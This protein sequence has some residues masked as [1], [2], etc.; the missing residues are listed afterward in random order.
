MSDYLRNVYVLL[1]SWVIFAFTYSIVYPYIELYFTELGGSLSLVGIVFS[2]TPLTASLFYI[3][4][5]YIADHY[6]RRW[7]ITRVSILVAIVCLGYALSPSWQF[8]LL[9]IILEGIVGIYRPALWA[10]YADSLPKDRLASGFLLA[11]VLPRVATI[12][13]PYI[14]GMLADTYHIMGYRYGFIIAAIVASI[15]AIIRMKYIVETHRVKVTKWSDIPWRRVIRESWG[16]I[17]STMKGLPRRLIAV[18]ISAIVFHMSS[19]IYGSYRVIVAVKFMGY[20]RS[21]IGFTLSCA[22][23]I[24]ALW[25]IIMVKYRII[26]RLPKVKTMALIMALYSLIYLIYTRGDLLSIFISFSLSVI[27]GNTWASLYNSYLMEISP[28]EVRA[29]IHAIRMIILAIATVCGGILAGILYSIYPQQ[30]LLLFYASSVLA[31][32]SV[33]LLKVLI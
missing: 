10:L 8:I 18:F 26:D 25:S 16:D 11:S 29:R 24:L 23:L 32:I 22:Y 31:V 4:G 3:I 12:P 7:L 20:S 15:I 1:V 27:S 19:H 6:G 5:S 13:S 30:P 2:L 17:I 14:G 9:F 21:T 33:I 28:I